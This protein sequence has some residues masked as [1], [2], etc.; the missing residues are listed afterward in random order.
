M[1][2]DYIPARLTE[3]KTWCVVYYVE[4]PISKKS[5]APVCSG[6]PGIRAALPNR[7]GF[8]SSPKRGYATRLFS[9]KWNLPH[10]KAP[11]VLYVGRDF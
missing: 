5:F 10:G 7:R 4:N 8:T 1:L 2:I 9:R 11:L 3:G 6:R